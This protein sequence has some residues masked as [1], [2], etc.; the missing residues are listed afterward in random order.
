MSVV[1]VPE[2]D[3]APR[4]FY[5]ILR[6]KGVVVEERGKTSL[7][8]AL[9]CVMKLICLKSIVMSLLIKYP[10]FSERKIW[11]TST[12]LMIMKESVILRTIGDATSA[13]YIIHK[14]PNY[15]DSLSLL[16]Y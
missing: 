16:S 14:M 8:N 4:C 12:T 5:P 10:V 3:L 6:T 15:N 1:E 2:E 9:K 11:G 13:K 7:I